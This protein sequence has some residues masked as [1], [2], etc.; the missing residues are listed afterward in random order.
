MYNDEDLAS[1]VEAG[2]FSEATVAVFRQHVDE[3]RQSSAIDDWWHFIIDVGFLAYLPGV[4]CGFLSQC[5]S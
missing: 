1:A 2:V 3:L 4:R 5:Y